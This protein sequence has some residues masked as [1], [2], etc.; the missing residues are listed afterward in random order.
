MDDAIPRPSRPAI[1]PLEEPASRPTKLFPSRTR[2]SLGGKVRCL[3]CN[4]M[5]DSPDR[6]R[7]RVCGAC[8]SGRE[9]TG[10]VGERASNVDRSVVG[11]AGGDGY[12]DG[13]RSNENESDFMHASDDD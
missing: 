5:W 3:Q 7:R 6:R 8:T 10:L 11:S 9:R 13:Y 1:N 4:E 2:P 12:Q